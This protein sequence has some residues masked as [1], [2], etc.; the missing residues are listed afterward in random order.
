MNEP[1]YEFVKG[2]GWVVQ[3]LSIITLGDGTRVSIE[4]RLPLPGEF[5]WVVCNGSYVSYKYGL[6]AESVGRWL[7]KYFRSLNAFMICYFNDD[8]IKPK[9]GHFHYVA[10][11][12]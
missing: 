11:P 9:E 6:G 5:Y 2:K 12:V 8:E 7:A 3:T 4:Q 10:V 1:I